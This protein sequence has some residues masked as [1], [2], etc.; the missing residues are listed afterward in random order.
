MIY[1]Y[2]ELLWKK[3]WT[4]S[5]KVLLKREDFTVIILSK[6]TVYLFLGSEQYVRWHL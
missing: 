1:F 3:S 4:L 2:A 6:L 5:F